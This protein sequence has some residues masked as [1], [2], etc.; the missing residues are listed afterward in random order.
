MNKNNKNN[1][2]NKKIILQVRFSKKEVIYFLIKIKRK[3]K[4]KFKIN[5]ISK[6][7][8]QRKVNK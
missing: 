5:K 3:N 1:K 8:I 7:L 4:N 6:D 2:F